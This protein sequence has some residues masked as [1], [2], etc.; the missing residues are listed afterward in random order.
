MYKVRDTIIFLPFDVRKY[1]AWSTIY[2]HS[3]FIFV[4]HINPFSRKHVFLTHCSPTGRGEIRLTNPHTWGVIGANFLKFQL[5]FAPLSTMCI[6]FPV[7]WL[8]FALKIQEQYETRDVGS[9]SHQIRVFQL[10]VHCSWM[11]VRSD[12]LRYFAW[13]R[14]SVSFP[15]VSCFTPSWQ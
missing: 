13:T 7:P 11:V 12:G 14:W 1:I 5:H 4:T 3:K 8:N 10:F 6:R 2:K 15:G 9:Q